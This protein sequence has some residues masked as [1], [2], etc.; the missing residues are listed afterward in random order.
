[1]L[2]TLYYLIVLKYCYLGNVA[3]YY[4][5]KIPFVKSNFKKD[6]DILS[7]FIAFIISLIFIS[8]KSLS[9]IVISVMI[10]YIY[11]LF[12]MGETSTSA[13]LQT[14]I[15]V[16]IVSS[17]FSTKI[18]SVSNDKLYA[19]KMLRINAKDYIL[20]DYLF[21]I[22]KIII[23]YYLGYII[24]DYMYVIPY[25]QNDLDITLYAI[26]SGIIVILI[27]NIFTWIN[28]RKYEKNKE[29]K[30]S[31][32]NYLFALII[33]FI[34][35]IS[36]YYSVIINIYI[37][38]AIIFILIFI[39][40]YAIKKIF[41]YNEFYKLFNDLCSSGFNIVN[42]KEKRNELIKNNIKNQIDNDTNHIT[43]KKGYDYFNEIF[44][45]RHKK[46][47]MK[48][49]K[50]TFVILLAIF[51]F[52]TYSIIN[53]K[54]LYFEINDFLI[55]HM[56]FFILIIY[57]INRGGVVIQAF[58]VNC[59][60][61]LLTYN[62]YRNPKTIVSIFIRRIKSLILINLLPVSVIAIFLPLLLF[63]TGGTEK[64]YI[65]PLISLT[66][67]SISIFFSIHYLI[68]YYIFQ[69]YNSY[70]KMKNPIYNIIMIFTYMAC[71]Y[72]YS[73]RINV[74]LFCLVTILFTLLYTIIGIYVTY[75]LAPK[76]FKLKND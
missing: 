16:T 53:N 33:I 14:F 11:P 48:S 8:L 60:S 47:L 19:I 68:I 56:P 35:Y 18:F 24:L 6:N 44:I 70:L 42:I 61:S 32:I 51:M 69:P 28:L 67:L 5:K 13:Y 76:T 36:V 52:V 22:V 37:L 10:F 71:F 75:K 73:I 40:F 15:L 57:I 20:I 21:D 2:S 46:I 38:L 29:I 62:F 26:L 49:A 4:L 72:I 64:L 54:N 17:L 41:E 12:I 27:K 3:L 55:Y 63:I 43:S 9:T 66:V 31:K 59:D 30:V 34:A 25:L 7:K 39:N 58:F 50:K 45:S 23:F 74:V 1:M 65:Y